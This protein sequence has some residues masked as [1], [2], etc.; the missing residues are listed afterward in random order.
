MSTAKHTP[1]VRAQ[2]EID[3]ATDIYMKLQYLGEESLNKLLFSVVTA[4]KRKNGRLDDYF[5]TFVRKA[6]PTCDAHNDLLKALKEF[7]ALG[8][9]ERGRDELW[10]SWQKRVS[11]WKQAIAAIAKAEGGAR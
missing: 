9:P 11:V 3:A 6:F 5:T 4:L 2:R 7:A 10:S 8:E 1:T